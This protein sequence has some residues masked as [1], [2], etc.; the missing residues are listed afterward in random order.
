M[1]GL[2]SFE[3]KGKIRL[4]PSPPPLLLAQELAPSLEGLDWGIGGSLLLWK[5]GLESM[6]RD[7]DI[8]TT[9]AHFPS[10]SQRIAHLLGAGVAVPHPTYRS[11]HFAR[12]A[13]QGPIS[14]DLFADVRVKMRDDLIDWTFDAR[15]VEHDLGLPWMLPGDWLELYELFNR[16]ERATA[17]RSFL[18]GS[19]R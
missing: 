14:V 11:V 8:M 9:S 3:L 4:T 19:N 17:L 5:L 6:P 1:Q 2:L 18:A 15:D 16:P 10:M 13:P 7:L 12:F